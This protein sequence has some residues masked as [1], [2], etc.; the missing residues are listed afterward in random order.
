MC[1]QEQQP[2]V[3]VKKYKNAQEVQAREEQKP[4]GRV[5]ASR[6]KAGT[7]LMLPSVGCPG[8]LLSISKMHT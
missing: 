2:E 7:E 3:S 5:Q 1:L 4:L 6:A 8:A